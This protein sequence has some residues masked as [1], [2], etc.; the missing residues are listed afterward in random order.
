MKPPHA[1]LRDIARFLTVA[2]F[3]QICKHYFAGDAERLRSVLRSAKAQ[4]LV[5]VSTELL[6]P[7]QHD[8]TPLAR[9]QLGGNS[10]A[11]G[12]IA[13]QARN[14]WSP[15]IVPTVVVRATAKLA[16]LCG[17]EVH[18]IARGHLSHSIAL[19][20]VYFLKKANE[21]PDMEWSLVSVKPGT[22][23]LPDAIAGS[24]AIEIIGRYSGASVAAKLAIASSMSLEVW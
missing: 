14:R 19:S 22:G 16:T 11:A 2:S 9:I 15:T 5:E 1:F 6:R 20:E 7:W 18:T 4:G 3:E 24:L 21:H 12:R 10:I 8:G 13:Y 23:S 17:G